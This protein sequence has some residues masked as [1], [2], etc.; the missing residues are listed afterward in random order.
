MTLGHIC[1]LNVFDQLHFSKTYHSQKQFV[2]VSMREP[3]K[4]LFV[5]GEITW[6]G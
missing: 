5:L 6:M 3:F 2:T 1:P 4:A